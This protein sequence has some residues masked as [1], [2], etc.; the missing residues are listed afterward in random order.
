MGNGYQVWGL[1]PFVGII[2]FGVSHFQSRRRG[3]FVHSSLSLRGRYD[4][5]NNQAARRRAQESE[6]QSTAIYRIEEGKPSL[7]WIVS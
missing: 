7:L 5:E 2:F 6:K 1:R 4:V 3:I